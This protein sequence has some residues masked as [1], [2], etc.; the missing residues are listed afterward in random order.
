LSGNNL[1]KRIKQAYTFNPE[2]T[3]AAA[4]FATK[5]SLKQAGYLN[6][7]GIRVGISPDG[8]HPLYYN[9]AG[10][11]LVVAPARTGKLVTILC[12]L[13][14]AL[15]R[16]YSLL[17]IDP[18]AEI[19]CIVGRTRRKRGALYVWNPYKI[20]LDHMR[21]L[22]QARLNPVA[23]I[24]PKSITVESDCKK[25]VM[26]FWD[27]AGTKN[28]PHWGPSGRSLF[29]AIIQ[30]LVKYGKPGEKNLPTARAIL[31]GANGHSLIEFARYIMTLPDPYLRE[32][33]AR[34][35]APGAEES[36][37]IQGLISTA[38]TQTDFLTNHAIAESL[39]AADVSFRQMKKEAGMTISVC[40]PVNR[41]D[42]AKCFSLLSGW[43]LHCT[44]EEGQRGG[45]VPCIAVVDEMSQIGFS[46][47]WLDAFGLAAGAAGLQIV[48]VYQDVSQIMNQFGKAWSSILQNCGVTLWFGARDQ[49]TRETVSKLAGLKEVLTQN[50]SVSIDL[51]SGE[52]LVSD[53]ASSVV[54]PV[55]HPH[56]VGQLRDDEMLMFCE[57]VPNPV[58]AKRKPYMSEFSGQY[59]PNPYFTK[60]GFWGWLFR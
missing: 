59:G 44:L 4:D 16:R 18:K 26:T 9:K 17:I 19:I 1:K 30:A 3:Q 31:T 32:E 5:K 24:D 42:D 58:K 46:K 50:R 34:Y 27:E 22:R 60:P 54:R 2:P 10:H 57:G 25:L 33:F 40:L 6:A 48:A 55:I 15:P 56:E 7:N 21:G 51:R 43:M 28:D 14:L 8:R 35:A 49:I 23:D 45:R 53:S 29:A 37:E 11:I 12:A 13:I 38:I 36:K 47:A 20:W 41:L 52:P 39:M